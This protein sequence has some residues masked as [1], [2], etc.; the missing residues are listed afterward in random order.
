MC[1]WRMEIGMDHR[2]RHPR[3]K[4]SQMEKGHSGRSSHRLVAQHVNP[5]RRRG[6]GAYTDTAGATTSQERAGNSST[7]PFVV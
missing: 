1:G 6:V 4:H 5:C 2:R 3:A 7:P